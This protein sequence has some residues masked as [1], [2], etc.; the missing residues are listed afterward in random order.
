MHREVTRSNGVGAGRVSAA[1]SMTRERRK[2]KLARD[3]EWYVEKEH[4]LLPYS[5]LFEVQ[6]FVSFPCNYDHLYPQPEAKFRL[7]IYL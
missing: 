3:H 2:R 6:I 7:H 4:R 5:F 1:K